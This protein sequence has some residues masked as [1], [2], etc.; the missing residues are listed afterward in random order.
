[1]TTTG[2]GLGRRGHRPAA[3]G[4]HL[5]RRRVLRPVKYVSAKAA[6]LTLTPAELAALDRS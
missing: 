5:R 2:T 6:D 1:M 3:C 4:R